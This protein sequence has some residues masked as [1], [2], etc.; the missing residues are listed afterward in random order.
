MG[1]RGESGHPTG[2]SRRGASGSRNGKR[3]RVAWQFST[4]KVE[5]LNRAGRCALPL[6]LLTFRWNSGLALL[7]PGS[8][9]PARA[10]RGADSGQASR[11]KAREGCGQHGP[12]PLDVCPLSA[13]VA[14]EGR[15]PGSWMHAAS[16]V[17]REAVPRMRHL[18]RRQRG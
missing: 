17:D 11:K 18:P 6:R 2:V 16:R 15:E 1:Q 4:V 8:R 12:S 9:V 5:D 7:P 3:K 10:T 13:T 14:G